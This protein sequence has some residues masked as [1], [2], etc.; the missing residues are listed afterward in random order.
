MVGLESPM[1][2]LDRFSWRN[3]TA[4]LDRRVLVV[5]ISDPSAIAVIIFTG[6]KALVALIVFEA[7]MF[8]APSIE[9]LLLPAPP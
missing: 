8:L 3:M 5:V 1:S 2:D 6:Q 4:L 7:L 9:F